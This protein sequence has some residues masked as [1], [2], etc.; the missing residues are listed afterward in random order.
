MQRPPGSMLSSSR[1]PPT[2]P[3]RTGLNSADEWSVS[4]IG[5]FGVRARVRASPPNRATSETRPLSEA[6][7]NHLN[8]FCRRRLG[9]PAPHPAM[10]IA[11]GFPDAASTRHVLVRRFGCGGPKCRRESKP[12]R[13][14]DCGQSPR[15]VFGST[16]SFVRL[17]SAHVPNSVG[18]RSSLPRWNSRIRAATCTTQSGRVR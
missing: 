9:A 10:F 1:L 14:R 5:S 16:S 3:S 13:S 7:E 11:E 4:T 18:Y 15:V 17:A 12:F 6:R 2:E 8:T